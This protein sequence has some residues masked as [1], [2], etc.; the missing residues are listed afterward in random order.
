MVIQQTFKK[1]RKIILSGTTG[2]NLNRD[3]FY[4]KEAFQ[5]LWPG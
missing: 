3:D 5:N 4:E 1:E 2:L